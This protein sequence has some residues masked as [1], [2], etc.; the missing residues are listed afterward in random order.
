[1]QKRSYTF[2]NEKN[3]CIA[4]LKDNFGVEFSGYPHV[5]IFE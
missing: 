3:E 5:F 2:K 4:N 1:M